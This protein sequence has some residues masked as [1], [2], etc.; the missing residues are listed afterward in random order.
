MRRGCKTGCEKKN[1]NVLLKQPSVF[2]CNVDLFKSMNAH[3]TVPYGDNHVLP[4][5]GVL[6]IYK[7]V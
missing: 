7:R 4:F 2:L 3:T 1:G 5:D 6:K